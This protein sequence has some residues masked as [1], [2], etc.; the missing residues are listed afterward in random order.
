MS[1][2]SSSAVLQLKRS[3]TFA[4]FRKAGAIRISGAKRW[5]NGS[6]KRPA[7]PI[8]GNPRSA[9]FANPIA[10]APTSRCAT[11]VFVRMRI[12]W[13]PAALRALWMRCSLEPPALASRSSV[14]KRSGGDSQRIVADAATL[15]HGVPVEHLMHDGKIRPHLPTAGVPRHRNGD[16]A[17]R[18]NLRRGLDA[19]LSEFDFSVFAD[20]E[21]RVEGDHLVLFLDATVYVEAVA[22]GCRRVSYHG[23]P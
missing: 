6:R 1:S 7:A 12:T 16:A 3:S 15:L 9:V 13:K 19:G 2:P 10:I 11:N 17:L 5:R 4:L 18:P 20:H 14:P 23:P 8:S 21:A 22:D